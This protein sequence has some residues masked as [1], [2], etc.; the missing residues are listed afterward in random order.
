MSPSTENKASRTRSEVGRVD[1]PPGAISRRPPKR[2]AMT[3]ILRRPA[4]YQRYVTPKEPLF[5]PMFGC[6]LHPV[7]GAS[8]ADLLVISK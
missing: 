8:S 6:T 7:F 5:S 1:A 2:P 3:R 4:G